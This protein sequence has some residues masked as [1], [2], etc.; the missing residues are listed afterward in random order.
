MHTGKPMMDRGL[1]PL[2]DR[3]ASGG[4]ASQPSAS[5]PLSPGSLTWVSLLTLSGCV[6]TGASSRGERQLMR[7]SLG[8]F[9]TDKSGNIERNE[10][11][12]LLEC[13]GQVC[14]APYLIASRFAHLRGRARNSR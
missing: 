5:G 14:A 13:M 3:S 12:P 7:E 11:G 8:R 10:L 6:C 9:D 4:V 1:C 2:Y